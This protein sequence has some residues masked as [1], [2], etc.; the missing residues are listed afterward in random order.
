[1]TA[2]AVAT[3]TRPFVTI[4]PGPRN[5]FTDPDTG[6]RFYRWQGRDL[7]SVTSS[8][9]MAGLPFGLHNWTLN[10]V[11]NHALDNLP[12]LSR[13]LGSGDPGVLQVLRHEL[14][15][16][17]TAE[18]DKAAKLGTAVHDAAASGLALTQV[19][20]EVAPRLRQYMAWLRASGAEVIGSEFQVFNLTVGYAGSVDLLVRFPNGQVW[21]VDLKTGRG[22]YSDHSLQVVAYAGAEF[23]GADDIVDEDLTRLLQ[24]VRGVAVLHLSDAGW[25]FHAIRWDSETWRAFCGLLEF[26]TWSHTHPDLGTFVTGSREGRDSE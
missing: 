4:E 7:P 24:Q 2:G 5:A 9:R 8:R 21:L 3:E 14:R 25:S 17:A 6:L 10:Q 13:R 16:A 12:E 22:I 19:P 18:R 15:G 26:A 20:A 11:I 23:V 1:M